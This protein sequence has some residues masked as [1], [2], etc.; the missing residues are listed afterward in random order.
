MELWTEWDYFV[1]HDTR[2]KLYCKDS[3]ISVQRMVWKVG[4]MEDQGQR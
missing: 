4:R 1:F 3:S 2:G